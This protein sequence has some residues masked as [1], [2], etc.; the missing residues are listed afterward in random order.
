MPSVETSHS[1]SHYKFKKYDLKK[2]RILLIADILRFCTDGKILKAVQS[3]AKNPEFLNELRSIVNLLKYGK[4]TLYA[5]ITLALFND[6][7]GMVILKN[8][9]KYWVTSSEIEKLHVCAALIL[10]KEITSDKFS[11]VNASMSPELYKEI[12]G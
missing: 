6:A 8:Y 9:Q 7:K 3:A 11:A 12:Q 5:A 2:I 10:L 1:P 4:E